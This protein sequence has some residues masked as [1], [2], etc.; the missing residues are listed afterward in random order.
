[1]NK[2]IPVLFFSLLTVLV[3]AQNDVPD[4]PRA[5]AEWEEVQAVVINWGDFV[6][7][8]WIDDGTDNKLLI[9]QH[10]DERRA[11][12]ELIS[13]VSKVVKVYVVDS[14]D[15]R[16]EEEMTG[17]GVDL[18]SV[19]I[20]SPDAP[21]SMWTRDYG[22]FSVYQNTAN[23]LTLVKT[24]YYSGKVDISP[25][26]LEKVDA[27]FYDISEDPEKLVF[28][29]GNFLTDGYGRLF[30]DK[31]TVPTG[32]TVDDY[33]PLLEKAFGLTDVVAF[34]KIDFHI[35]YYLKLIN[36]ETFLVS[37][38]SGGFISNAQQYNSKVEEAVEWI[39]NNLKT[40]FGRDYSF[41]YIETPP[42]YDNTQENFTSLSNDM[43]YINSLIVNDHVFVPQYGF[44]PY[45]SLALAVYDSV[46]PGYTLVP[47]NYRPW[48]ARSGSIHCV[49][50]E[51]GV[52]DP[53]YISHAW[54]KDTVRQPVPEVKALVSSADVI[55]K[56]TLHWTLDT[57]AGF[58]S[59]EMQPEDDGIYSAAFPVTGKNEVFYYLSAQTGIGK[60]VTRPFP[61]MKGPYRFYATGLGT[62]T[63][64]TIKPEGLL[65]Q[66][67]PNPF[68]EQT[69][70]EF[71]VPEGNNSPV[72]LSVHDI[73]G[74][75]VRILFDE[76]NATGL[77]R[78]TMDGAGL[79]P[80]IFYY[81]LSYG[82]ATQTRKMVKTK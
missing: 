81:R 46:M 29:G 1:M 31:T 75:L 45:D 22:P 73:S 21:V 37:K 33:K 68:G 17:L 51:I 72:R 32:T 77:H 25:Q 79:L 78:I 9:K 8:S 6:W 66:N 69:T 55:Q 57:T 52:N 28:D 42:D 24:R 15:G 4:N 63:D 18:S 14:R 58:Q 41:V 56:V 35:D 62:G 50:R 30:L 10:N 65:E 20:L 19:E 13:A 54:L 36:E 60:T 38:I 70:I 74:R 40:P 44:E 80:G 64:L 67:F 34:D 12:A 61:G 7:Q 71:R 59:L 5:M 11:A 16:A 49:T 27:R 76:K 2:I 53:L 43:T 3:P 47:V 82:E 48:S 39:K 26:L 23:S